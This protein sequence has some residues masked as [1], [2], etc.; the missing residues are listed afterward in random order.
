MATDSL[1]FKSGL[2]DS[3]FQAGLKRMDKGAAQLG[4]SMAKAFAGGAAIGGLATIGTMLKNVTNES[5]EF[6]SVFSS[7]TRSRTIGRDSLIET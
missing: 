1:D 6:G 5:I 3:K 2:D 4:A 7:G